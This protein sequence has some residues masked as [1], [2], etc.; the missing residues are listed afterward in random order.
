MSEAG[1]S[2]SRILIVRLG[3]MGD[4]IHTLPAAA[5][6][7]ASFPRARITWVVEPQW[8]PLL[9]DNPSLD[10][11]VAFHRDRPGFMSSVRSLRSEPYDL[12]LDFQGLI[13]SAAVGCLARPSRLLGYRRGIA[14][15]GAAA[16]LYSETIDTRST[17][18]V[19]MRLDL[20]AAAG[21]SN[22]VRAFALPEG[23]P[24]G[25][26]PAGDYVLAS[27]LAGWRSKQWPMEHYRDLA[28][29]LRRD[30]GIPLVLNGPPAALAELST[31]ADAIP[32]VC[33]IAG[34]IHATRRAAAVIGVDSGPL[35]I[36]AALHKPGVAIFG[37][38]DPARNGP[39]CD[40]LQVL[41]APD[42]VTTYKRGDA[43]DRSMWQV[44][45]DLVFDALKAG[46]LA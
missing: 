24:E 17:H 19:E 30:L 16:W 41:R 28:V 2:V 7:R 1:K 18:V 42:A 15:E 37:P 43:P 21:A 23:R 11:V 27:P 29:R 20:A 12:A 36:A 3:A 33:G 25:N 45:P 22:M 10:R 26:L 46:C 40:S 5:S 4:I 39:Y 38:T 6:L 9:Q 31:V 34:L 32:H 35:H 13:K 44:P 8:M 14:R